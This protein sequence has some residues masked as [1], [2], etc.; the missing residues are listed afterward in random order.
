MKPIRLAKA[1]LVAAIGLFALLVGYNNIVDYDSNFEFVRH[2]MLMDTTFP[3]NALRGRAI[4]SGVLH[5][6]L[7]VMIILG[8]LLCG[9]L[10]L[11]GAARLALRMRASAAEFD[12]ARGTAVLGLALGF[13][14]WFCGFL[15]VGGE[16]FL[17]WQSDKWN[18]Q[19][20]AFRVVTCI[21][22]VLVF[23]CQATPEES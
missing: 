5:Q 22:L 17:M 10:C 2:V 4:E 11:A 7:Y 19:L 6:A 14:L 13:L 9:G 16:W 3:G 1:A 12:R 23:L 18:G 8:E 20:A 21:G 15:V